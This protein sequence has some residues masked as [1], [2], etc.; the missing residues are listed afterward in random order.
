MKEAN[1]VEQTD[2]QEETKLGDALLPLVR[3]GYNEALKDVEKFLSENS[4]C[5]NDM[6][7]DY[8]NFKIEQE[9]TPKDIDPYILFDLFVNPY[10]K[11]ET[12]NIFKDKISPEATWKER[13]WFRELCRQARMHS[14]YKE[15]IGGCALDYEDWKDYFEDNIEPED[16][17]TE[18]LS[19]I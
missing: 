13:A 19:N 15:V 11:F 1:E 14:V 18:D 10:G 3:Y 12:T 8:I 7:V 16:A 2:L 5:S 17:I 6:V 4:L 9:K